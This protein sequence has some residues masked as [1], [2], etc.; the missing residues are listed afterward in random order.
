[1]RRT[2]AAMDRKSEQTEKMERMDNAAKLQKEQIAE[3]VARRHAAAHERALARKEAAKGIRPSIVKRVL[4]ARENAKRRREEKK[5][6]AEKH[7]RKVAKQ[8]AN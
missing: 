1:M 3:G 6:R 2:E 8:Q 4:T 7:A 5:R